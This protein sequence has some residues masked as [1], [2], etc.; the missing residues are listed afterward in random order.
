[1]ADAHGG[2]V[3]GVGRRK[4]AVARVRLKAG[5]GVL[6]V[7]GKEA[8]EYFR[9]DRDRASIRQP[10]AVH[11]DTKYDILVKVTGGG[12]TGQAGAIVM[13]IARAMAKVEPALGPKLRAAGFLTRD[14]RMVER[15]KYGQ[16]KARRR[17]Q[18]SKR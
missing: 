18:Y 14:S 9:S 2:M 4:E 15:K 1:M 5:T 12:S 13:G 17:F 6:K 16:K 8:N 11:A 10:L 7:N 3:W